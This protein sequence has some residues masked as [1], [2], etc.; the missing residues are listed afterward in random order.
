MEKAL[1]R[2]GNRFVALFAVIALVMFAMCQ[3]APAVAQA[4]SQGEAQA[5]TALADTSGID[6]PTQ[7]VQTIVDTVVNGSGGMVSPTMAL[8]VMGILM[9]GLYR[10]LQWVAAK[11]KTPVGSMGTNALAGLIALLFGSEAAWKNRVIAKGAPKYAAKE[12]K[13]KLI[14]RLRKDHP[15]LATDLSKLMASNLNDMPTIY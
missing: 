12:V 3:I 2:S 14:E 8:T 11:S 13:I 10:L 4:G 9:I 7:I 5:V 1:W 15:I 6:A